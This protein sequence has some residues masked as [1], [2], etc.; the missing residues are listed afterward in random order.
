MDEHNFSMEIWFTNLFC[1]NLYYILQRCCHG[2]SKM[3]VKITRSK[4]TSPPK[5]SLIPF[6]CSFQVPPHNLDIC[7]VYNKH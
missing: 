6:H 4:I 7:F 2:S 1:V 5:I 3:T